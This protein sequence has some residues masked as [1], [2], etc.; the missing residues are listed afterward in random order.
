MNIKEYKVSKILFIK[1]VF[2]K[3][4][5]EID[6]FFE[7]QIMDQLNIA[8][9]DEI[10]SLP[11]NFTDMQNWIKKTNIKCWYCDLNFEV[12][13]VFIPRII[14]PA[15]T[16]SG[17]NIGVYGCFC[18]FPCAKSFINLTYSNL[19]KNTSITEML[20][21]L[22]NIFTNNT[23]KEIFPSPEKYIMKKYGGYLD[24]SEYRN[25]ID[26]IN[27]RIHESS[28]KTK[29]IVKVPCDTSLSFLKKTQ[30]DKSID[31]FINELND[32]ANNYENSIEFIH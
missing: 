25:K 12:T 9:I 6:D 11:Y 24:D 5:N 7:K 27:K 31:I 29:K 18:S 19:C 30:I 23:V 32:N 28:I 17:F 21:F 2:I 22:Y 13:P 3:D 1:G 10:I 8:P 20:L 15:N 16:N 26:I 14:E 4:C